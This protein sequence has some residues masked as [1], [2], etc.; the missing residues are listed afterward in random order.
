MQFTEK[1]DAKTA[2]AYLESGDYAWN[3]GLFVLRAST[4]LNAIAQFRKDIYSACL[5]SWQSKREDNMGE[6]VFIRPDQ[7]RFFANTS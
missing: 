2:Q 1:P 3:S 7:E 4:W 5:L 6:A